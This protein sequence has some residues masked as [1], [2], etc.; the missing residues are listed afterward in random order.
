MV[1]G[2]MFKPRVDLVDPSLS[3]LENDQSVALSHTVPLLS[4]FLEVAF[5]SV[6]TCLD[7]STVSAS[8][9]EIC[10]EFW[11]LP[12]AVAGKC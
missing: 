2:S 3:L 9:H 11:C 10:H 6:G 5:S 4:V 12:A 7:P 1:C 8:R